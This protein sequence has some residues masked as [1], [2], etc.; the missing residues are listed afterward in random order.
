MRSCCLPSVCKS[1]QCGAKCLLIR[2][3]LRAQTRGD[4]SVIQGPA[5]GQNAIFF[6]EFASN[7]GH[8]G[9]ASQLCCGNKEIRFADTQQD[10]AF[11]MHF[12]LCLASITKPMGCDALKQLVPEDRKSVV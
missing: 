3:G 8:G 2:D 9:H 10:H 11:G 12:D 4:L 7:T 5:D 1:V 6:D